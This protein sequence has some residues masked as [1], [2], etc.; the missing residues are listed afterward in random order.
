MDQ[1]HA[2]STMGDILIRAI[3][4]GGDRT[5]FI[6]DGKRTTYRDFGALLSRMLQVFERHGVRRGD[7][8]ACLSRNSMEAF[9]IGAACYLSG[10]RLTNLHPLASA[11]DQIFM[12]EDSGAKAFFFDPATFADR[13]RAI[14]SR[15][16]C[17]EAMALGPSE[18]A[19]DVL[20]EAGSFPARDLVSNARPSDLCWLIYTGGTTGRPKG[21]MHS[22]RTHVAMTMAELA[23]WEWPRAPVF[24]ATTPISHGAGGCLLPVLVLSGTVVMANGFS[25]EG[26]FEV[27]RSYGVSATFLVPTM[28]YKL[29]DHA[30]SHDVRD[31]GLELVIYGAA[32]MTPVRLREAIERFGP[33]FMQLYGQSEAPNSVTVLRRDDHLSIDNRRLTSCGVPIGNS[34]V[35]LLN[36][37]GGQVG[38]GELGEICVRGP[39]VMEGYWNRPEETAHA[40]RDGW[41]HTGDLARCDDDGFF[42]IVGRSKDMIITGGFNVYPSEVEDVLTAHEAVSAAAIIGLPDPVWG[43]AVTAVVVLRENM[44]ASEADLI[45]WVRQAKGPVCAPKAIHFR[46]DIPLTSLGKPDKKALRESLQPTPA[47]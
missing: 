40:F 24:L 44:T 36:E 23:E 45:A 20:A 21:V 14:V 11:E 1:L 46:Q 22:H 33:I 16:R 18:T 15:V 17:V 13:A 43:E 19:V 28:I 31:I 12:L 8:V 9:L 25:P 34:Q 27:V 47:P 39:L 42:Y 2:S 26:F 4:R 5:A 37:E 10:A 35:A 41:L 38:A 30:A 3:R 7:G 6:S 29:L 32:P